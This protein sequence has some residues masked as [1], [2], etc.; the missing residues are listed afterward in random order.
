MS[1]KKCGKCGVL[2]DVG[3]FYFHNKV[4]GTLQSQCKACSRLASKQWADDNKDKTKAWRDGNKDRTAAWRAANA[5]RL[6]EAH[7]RA[8]AEKVLKE[9]GRLPKS[10]AYGYTAYSFSSAVFERNRHLEKLFHGLHESAR[11]ACESIYHIRKRMGR[12]TGQKFHVDHIVP[13]KGEN[14]SG[15][16]VPWNLR[17]VPATVNQKKWAKT[18]GDEYWSKDDVNEFTIWVYE[19][20]GFD[21]DMPQEDWRWPMGL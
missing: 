9:K 19:A 13:I 5:D 12:E 17:I 4:K 8:Y 7:R 10:S 11:Q 14:I 1:D 3:E 6:K 15:L 20:N 2:K 16:H 18:E 21:W